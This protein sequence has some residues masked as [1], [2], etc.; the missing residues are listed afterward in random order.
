MGNKI[1][2]SRAHSSDPL[3]LTRS[4]CYV[5]IMP[6]SDESIKGSLH[7]RITALLIKPSTDNGVSNM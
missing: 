3:P 1:Y 2:L 5:S 6:P 4:F 7:L